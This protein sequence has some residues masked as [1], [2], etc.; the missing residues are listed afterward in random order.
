MA[1]I[2]Y[3]ATAPDFTTA[4]HAAARAALKA[5]IPTITDAIAAASL[6]AVWITQARAEEAARRRTMEEQEAAAAEQRRR[7]EEADEILRAAE[8]AE[9]ET[10]MREEMKK[11]KA[12]HMKIAVGVALP[13]DRP[14]NAP[15]A[16]MKRLKA[17]KYVPMWHFTDEGMKQGAKDI[18]VE[19][20]TPLRV[21][22]GGD[23]EGEVLLAA[24]SRSLVTK[25]KDD[26][27]TW[28]EFSVAGQRFI[29]AI[30]LAG[31]SSE[32]VA[33]FGRFY[34]AISLHKWRTEV[35]PMGIK[36]RALLIYAGAQRVL[37]HERLE[38]DPETIEDLSVI[39][40]ESLMWAKDDAYDRWRLRQEKERRNERVSRP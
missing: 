22:E 26:E 24:G 9:R 37:W 34:S 6:K 7:D 38:L 13:S 5:Q 39:N 11:N 40:L 16:V 4:E 30:R 12:K 20:S 17:G 21:L 25:V 28:E 32:H 19:E 29:E 33:M 18:T 31:W 15:P 35:D 14:M 27:L 3:E 10:A 23:G 2:D 8:A 36:R 1:E